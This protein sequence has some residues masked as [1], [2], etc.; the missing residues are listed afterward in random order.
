MSAGL[1]PWKRPQPRQRVRPI[2]PRLAHR[3]VGRFAAAALAGLAV[4]ALSAPAAVP[5]PAPGGDGGPLPAGYIVVDAD[6]GAVI[7]AHDEHRAVPPA[8]TVKLMTA[9]VGLERLAPDASLQISSLVE[10]Q[11]ASKITMRAGEIWS[12]G[13]ALH[14]LLMASAND[15]AYAIAEN[16]AGSLEGFADAMAATGDRMGLVDSTFN[17]PAGLDAAGEGFRGGSSVSAFDLAIVARNALALPAIATAAARRNDYP[18]TAPNGTPRTIPNHNDTWLT[19]YPGANGLKAGHTKRA[20]RTFVA[21]ATR[22]GRTCIAVVLGIPD[23]LGWAT[24]LNDQCFATPV[25]AQDGL[26][27]IPEVRTVTLRTRQEAVAGFPR[28]LGAFATAV[29][30]EPTEPADAV[31]EPVADP[32]ATRSA[33]ASSPETS[34]PKTP[35]AASSSSGLVSARNAALVTMAGLGVAFVVRRRQV[36][37]QRRKRRARQK[38]LHDAQRRGVRQVLEPNAAPSDSVTVSVLNQPRRTRPSTK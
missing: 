16:A 29:P 21:S 14:A 13:D 10:S 28:V 36:R 1:T 32:P 24:R 37:H 27:T 31:R 5:A 20:N 4:L 19:A 2:A 17:D 38:K 22:D 18:F 11:P 30:G 15:A 23:T 7:A 26:E 35:A 25:A 33:N 6:T 9:L 8:S 3:F 12:M 34:S